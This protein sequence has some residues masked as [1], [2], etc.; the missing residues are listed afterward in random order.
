MPIRL[1]G[2]RLP[3]DA[4]P[5]RAI[6]ALLRE[7]LG[8]AAG[9]RWRW[10]VARR[11]IDARKQPVRFVLSVDVELDGAPPEA[12]GLLPPP[13]EETPAPDP[14]AEPLSG[15]PLVVGAGPAG[16][17]A[18]LLLAEHGYRPLIIDRGGTVAER[19]AALDRFRRTR[20]PDP[21]CNALFGLGGAGTFSDGKLASSQDHPWVRHVLRTLVVCG[22]PAEILVDARPHVGTD[23]LGAVVARLAARI[24]AAGG[25]VR[26]G[27]RMDGLRLRGGELAG[28]ETSAGFLPC[29]VAVLA[30]G[31]SARDTWL[32]LE[33]DGLTLQPKPFQ[34]GVRAEHPQAWV[35]RR[36]YGASAG[37]P[38]LG[39][40]EYK[41]TARVE[42][43]PVFSFCMCPG[44]STMPTVNEAG[45]LCLNGMSASRRD[46]PCASSGL[47][48]SLRPEDLG[49]HTPADCLAWVRSVEAACFAAGGADY[50]APAQG[51]VDFLRDRASPIPPAA[52]YPLGVRS[53]RLDE[54]LPAAVVRALRPALRTFDRRMPGYLHPEALLLAPESRA[55]SPLRLTRDP[56]TR[57][58]VGGPGLYPVGEGAGY[59]GGIVSAALDGLKSAA[60]VIGKHSPPT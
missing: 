23:L 43:V 7:R 9:G 12:S 27:V 26:T 46:S 40:A 48:V 19:E 41:L 10:T 34:L 47:V 28:L 20:D 54:V 29:P 38:A 25:S 5:D 15:P 21:E 50:T 51:L 13:P 22:A 60:R 8:D 24:E 3:V 58:A 4:D 14:G 36:Q 45:H 32:A 52:S 17:F 59:A 49:L 42:G 56:E 39:A 31:H 1:H 55:S 16:L 11:S 53:V 57:E 37:H 44:G 33:R 35:D 30:T 18:G 2:L 6:P